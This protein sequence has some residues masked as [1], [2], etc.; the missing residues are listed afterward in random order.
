MD[1]MEQTV[2]DTNCTIWATLTF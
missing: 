1:L 2:D